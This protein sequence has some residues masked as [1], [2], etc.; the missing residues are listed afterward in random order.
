L[1]NQ[2]S[3]HCLDPLFLQ[4]KGKT[5]RT[6]AYATCKKSL[7]IAGRLTE[8][9]L[10]AVLRAEKE[11]L[12]N[13][14][15][16]L[17]PLALPHPSHGL[18]TAADTAAAAAA[19]G[20]DPTQG[21]GDPL[22]SDAAAGKQDTDPQ[23]PLGLSNPG[24]DTA[25]AAAGRGGSYR[26]PGSPL[27]APGLTPRFPGGPG[28]PP[29]FTVAAA[30][31][32]THGLGGLCLPPEV[33]AALGSHEVWPGLPGSSQAPVGG[34]FGAAPGSMEPLLSTMGLAS[35]LQPAGHQ[36][37]C[38]FSGSLH[39]SHPH[40]SLWGC[41][42]SI[43]GL[44]TAGGKGPAAAGTAAGAGGTGG[45]TPNGVGDPLK[46]LEPYGCL[47]GHHSS[48]NSIQTRPDSA[49]EAMPPHGPRA[50]AAAVG[51]RIDPHE[52]SQGLGEI[53]GHPASRPSSRQG[54][55]PGGHGLNPTSVSPDVGYSSHGLQ[56]GHVDD[57]RA[58]G[59]VDHVPRS[60][61]ANSSL[62][63]ASMQHHAVY[64]AVATD[65]PYDSPSVGAGVYQNYG[66]RGR[67]QLQQAACSN[68]YERQWGAPQQQQRQQ[69]G[70]RGSSPADS[71]AN[72]DLAHEAPVPGYAPNLGRY[73]TG[74][75]PDCK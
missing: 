63:E 52:Y 7:A 47:Q 1:L 55:G 46:I 59:Y 64:S 73:T 22:E 70:S 15:A 41:L 29:G 69:Q 25:A 48:S 51:A 5:S 71:G 4:N 23:G 65:S 39:P 61:P 26:G 67:S 62:Q 9:T 53:P 60:I 44:G 75:A 31:E 18:C 58:C 14:D 45:Y 3:T 42:P 57:S 49:L 27:P 6:D 19:A 36:Q 40:D 28:G 43:R 30:F 10:R 33:M 21:G 74:H 56:H 32:G 17:H 35:D 11:F 66:P 34:P 72:Y 24:A 54:L 38:V 20:L 68:G 13:P 8:R 2:V 37:G 12:E 50:A 16:E